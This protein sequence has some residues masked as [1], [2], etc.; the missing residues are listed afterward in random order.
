MRRACRATR[1]RRV[2]TLAEL[3]FANRQG[4]RVHDRI[5]QLRLLHRLGQ[6]RRRSHRFG[7]CS[8]SSPPIPPKSSELPSRSSCSARVSDPR[9]HL[10][11]VQA[12]A[13]AHRSTNRNGLPSAAA[14]FSISSAAFPFSAAT[15]FI[16]QFKIFLP[17]FP[18]WSRLS[19][20]TSTGRSR[21]FT[22]AT[23]SLPSVLARGAP[24]TAR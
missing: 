4:E 15:G 21:S 16:L 13:C 9:R 2:V 18:G 10:K 11:A 24:K 5:P 1:L 19:S 7:P 8:A 22:G 12:P 23:N 6:S 14:C 3:R 17:G 20:T